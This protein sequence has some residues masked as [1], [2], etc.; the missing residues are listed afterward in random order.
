[1]E[2]IL[3]CPVVAKFGIS[4]ASKLRKGTDDHSLNLRPVFKNV[5]P[6]KGKENTLP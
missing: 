4:L 3:K 5:P 2:D 6:R 1:M